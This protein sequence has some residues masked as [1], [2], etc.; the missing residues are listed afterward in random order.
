MFHT[1][2]KPTSG[3]RPEKS[4]QGPTSELRDP[5]DKLRRRSFVDSGIQVV[6]CLFPRNS[7]IRQALPFK[8]RDS[9]MFRN[10]FS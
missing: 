5:F 2:P 9:W 8:E 10:T 6:A 4:V 3:S 7:N 1:S